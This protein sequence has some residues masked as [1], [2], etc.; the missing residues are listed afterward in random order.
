M[1]DSHFGIHDLHAVA[2][3]RDLLAEA[4]HSRRLTLARG[5][6]AVVPTYRAAVR[7]TVGVRLIQ[8]GHR[9]QGAATTPHASGQ[10]APVAC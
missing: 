1:N 7:W 10:T 8:I 4:A 5:A 6:R 3:R 2:R 9:I